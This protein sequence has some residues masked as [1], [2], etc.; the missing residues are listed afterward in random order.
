M[1]DQGRVSWNYQVSQAK[2][3]SKH[4]AV[5]E[6]VFEKAPDK[7]QVY[8]DSKNSKTQYPCYDTNYP[9]DYSATVGGW[10]YCPDRNEQGQELDTHILRMIMHGSRKKYEFH[11]I[12]EPKIELAMILKLDLQP[13]GGYTVGGVSVGS[14]KKKVTKEMKAKIVESF[15]AAMMLPL[16]KRLGIPLNKFKVVCVHRK[17][18]PCLKYRRRRAGEVTDESSSLGNATNTTGPLE[19][20]YE[21]QNLHGMDANLTDEN[22]TE[23]AAFRENVDFAKSL[24]AQMQNMT[25]SG[26]LDEVLNDTDVNSTDFVVASQAQ[27]V[28]V[29]SAIVDEGYAATANAAGLFVE[30]GSVD[31]NVIMDKDGNG[32]SERHDT[33]L[34]NVTLSLSA[35]GTTTATLA[36]AADGKFAFKDVPLGAY[37]LTIDEATLPP[38]Q[39]PFYWRLVSG[40]GTNPSPVHIHKIGAFHSR[41][42]ICL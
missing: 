5:V 34:S 16:S 41:W 32:L 15:A 28:A 40:E 17:G 10:S 37:N 19:F 13:I 25:A 1:S 14:G 23:T 7:M 29:D 3:E 20:N 30:V 42:P 6:V 39:T 11:G 8:V 2:G 18:E 35:N 26:G 9:L 12:D 33:V 4:V 31:G 24:V 36:T 38:R 21:V 22:G 27:G